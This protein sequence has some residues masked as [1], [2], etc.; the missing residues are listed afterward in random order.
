M[1][2]LDNVLDLVQVPLQESALVTTVLWQNAKK[3][4]LPCQLC[5]SCCTSHNK[6]T[7]PIQLVYNLVVPLLIL[8]CQSNNTW[9]LI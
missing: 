5:G 1:V 3:I 6:T 8:L 9:T 7:I 4:K 2:G